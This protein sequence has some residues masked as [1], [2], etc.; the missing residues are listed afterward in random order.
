LVYIYGMEKKHGG[1]RSNS[2][3]KTELPTERMRPVTMTL[4]EMTLRRLKVVG[5]GNV[6]RAV[7]DAAALAYD[8]WQREQ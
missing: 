7:R 3:R 2:G 5:N 1:P 8:K 4:D 6:S